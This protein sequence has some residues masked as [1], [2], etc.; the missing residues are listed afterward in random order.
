MSRLHPRTLLRLAGR[1]GVRP[2]SSRP[3]PVE[4]VLDEAY[5]LPFLS[6]AH[7]N[8]LPV[9]SSSKVTLDILGMDPHADRG[10]RH[11]PDHEQP[12]ADDADLLSSLSGGALLSPSAAYRAL[13]QSPLFGAHLQSLLPRIGDVYTALKT[14]GEGEHNTLV[15]D[16]LL[17]S[18]S[19]AALRSILLVEVAHFPKHPG[20]VLRQGL[21]VQAYRAII[22]SL[23]RRTLAPLTSAS[24]AVIA[25]A[26]MAAGHAHVDILDH[27][28]YQLAH[29]ASWTRDDGWPALTILLHLSKHGRA[30]HALKLLDYPVSLG[31]L[32]AAMG[33]TSASHAEPATLLAQS[34]VIR[35]ALYWGLD[36]RAYSAVN[37]L[38]TTMSR[39]AVSGPALELVLTATRGAS[40]RRRPQDVAWAGRTLLALA[41]DEAFPPLPTIDWYYDALSPTAALQFYTS[42]PENRAAPPSPRQ[43][44]RM[45]LSR[46]EKASLRRLAGDLARAQHAAPIVPGMLKALAAA[47][48]LRPAEGIYVAWNKRNTLDGA[49]TLAMVHALTRGARTAKNSALARK[50]LK[51]YLTSPALDKESVALHAHALLGAPLEG[52]QD[53]L[54]DLVT[55]LV[56]S[57]GVEA[58]QGRIDD[59][60]RSHPSLAHRLAQIARD[61]ALAPPRQAVVMAASCAAG[62]WGALA[63][64]GGAKDAGIEDGK[65]GVGPKIAGTLVEEGCITALKKA[66]QGR[67]AVAVRRFTEASERDARVR[68]IDFMES[69]R[70]VDRRGREDLVGRRIH[71]LADPVIPPTAAALLRRCAGLQRWEEGFAVLSA[72]LRVTGEEGVVEAAGVFISAVSKADAG[73]VFINHVGKLGPLLEGLEPSS[74]VLLETMLDS[75]ARRLGQQIEG[76][77]TEEA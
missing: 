74:Q 5:S 75:A 10:P 31:K 53:E 3:A 50:I 18:P 68:G 26:V 70:Q 30:E 15:A 76:M 2:L 65:V 61:H 56:M 17:R 54:T 55:N 12:F 4:W 19:P 28:Y 64:A 66:R 41:A 13:R 14:D 62:H 40:L 45:S 29:A 24:L 46:P 25:R 39:T 32:P 52:E 23:R 63:A 34:A 22:P 58:A 47:R 37:D 36:S 73:D 33:R 51:D 38:V 7:A 43:I 35:C 49:T 9:P 57:R 8:Q 77:M 48:L 27:V 44:L 69:E 16:L 60:A 1:R 72:A 71:S 59:L 20:D 42:L 6:R 21:L 67:M 11:E